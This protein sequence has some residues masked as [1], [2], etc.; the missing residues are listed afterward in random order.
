MALPLIRPH[1]GHLPPEG[2]AIRGARAPMAAAHIIRAA[3]R[4]AKI[5]RLDLCAY[6]MLK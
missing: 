5:P 2:K 6:F 1:G 3:R 4:A